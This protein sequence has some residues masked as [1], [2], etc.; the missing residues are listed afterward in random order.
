MSPLTKRQLSKDEL[1]KVLLAVMLGVGVLL[2]FWQF[3]VKRAGEERKKVEKNILATQQDL[4]ENKRLVSVAAAKQALYDEARTK[5]SSIMASHI[6]PQENA[7]AWANDLF[8]RHVK[9]L[10]LDLQ[11]INENGI[12]R[13]PVSS[14]NRNAPPPLFEDYMIQVGMLGGYHDV[15]R[16]LAA[17]ETDNSYFRVD[18][19]ELRRESAKLENALGVTVVCAFP[20]LTE[21]AFPPE[22]RPDAERP[23]VKATK[24]GAKGA[25]KTP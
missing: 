10:R 19:L 5:L 23:T 4:E 6:P 24:A 9:G 13:L 25:A 12:D 15:G 21:E 2:C 22:E 14:G 17:L 1:Q 20:R 18:S 3:G 11:A 8:I 16:F 7:T